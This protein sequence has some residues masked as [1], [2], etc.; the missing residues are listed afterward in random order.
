MKT[1]IIV[2]IILF[3]LSVGGVGY[4]LY[5]LDKDKVNENT[6]SNANT[7]LTNITQSPAGSVLAL[8]DDIK[9]A[10]FVTLYNGDDEDIK[11]SPLANTEG[12]FM[13]PNLFTYTWGAPPLSED[14]AERDALFEDAG[15]GAVMYTM[16]GMEIIHIDGKTYQNIDI[17]TLIELNI[18]D[19]EDIA[20][21]GD[22]DFGGWRDVTYDGLH[23][24]PEEIR[25]FWALRGMA[26]NLTMQ[27]ENVYSG[28]IEYSALKS[29]RMKQ[30]R[31][32][33]P[34]DMR[35]PSF[36]ENFMPGL[37]EDDDTPPELSIEMVVTLDSRGLLET[38]RIEQEVYADDPDKIITT[39]SHFNTS[40]DFIMPVLVE[41]GEAPVSQVNFYRYKTAEYLT[42][43]LETIFDGKELPISEAVVQL[44]AFSDPVIA[45]LLSEL[46][47]YTLANTSE[48]TAE[49]EK[50]YW[51]S[52]FSDPRPGEYYYGYR[53]P[54]GKQF[55]I[56]FV[57]EQEDP[58]YPL[59]CDSSEGL[60]IDSIEGS[61]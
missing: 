27:S 26:E 34:R 13:L 6:V 54:D 17:D 12:D 22:L 56:S 38:V 32:T 29:A 23:Y 41:G 31:E 19:E 2:L 33:Q 15:L 11:Q 28:E 46:Q 49:E 30:L 55:S 7:T 20:A 44:D 42:A 21:A 58:D 37:N 18:I 35:Q 59:T 1:V 57:Q 8:L 14:E 4:Y 9:S 51:Q 60:C 39:F 43:R 40:I 47:V 61:I 16:Y 36:V 53:S 25:F 24:H 3:V 10:H 48:T 50:L 5:V 45:E 52:E